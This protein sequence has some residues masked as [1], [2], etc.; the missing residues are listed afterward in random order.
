MQLTNRLLSIISNTAIGIG[1]V[2]GMV[3]IVRGGSLF[4]A[5]GTAGVA[6]KARHLRRFDFYFPLVIAIALF[7]LAVALPRGR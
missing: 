6:F 5:V 7:A 4:I 3:G 2:L 1:V